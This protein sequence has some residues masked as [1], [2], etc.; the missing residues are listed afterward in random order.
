MT[1]KHHVLIALY[2]DGTASVHTFASADLRDVLYASMRSCGG[3]VRLARGRSTE[4][5]AVQHAE[6]AW[7]A[8]EV[9]LHG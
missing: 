9:S 2:A 3:P 8:A 6:S 4:Q 1:T 5:E 7:G